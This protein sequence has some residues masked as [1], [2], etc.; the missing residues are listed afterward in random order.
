MKLK[1]EVLAKIKNSTGIRGRICAETGKSFSTV[2]R[3][4]AKNDEGLTLAASLKVIREELGL[5]D[6][7]ILEEA[8]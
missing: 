4:V 7:Q 2:Q 5:T 1:K 6:K 3:W 8:A